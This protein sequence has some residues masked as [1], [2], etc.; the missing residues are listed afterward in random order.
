MVGGRYTDDIEV[1]NFS[2]IA[3]AFELP[4]H[5]IDD[6]SKL[7]LKIPEI[8]EIT[9]PVLTEIVCDPKQE[10]LEPYK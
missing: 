9:G 5:L 10:V 4:F 6:Y 7:D 8:L 2:K 1:L 3:E